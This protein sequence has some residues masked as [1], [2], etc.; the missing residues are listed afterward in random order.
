MKAFVFY[1]VQRVIIRGWSCS[2]I[3][4]HRFGH[5]YDFEALVWG[6]EHSGLR[7]PTFASSLFIII[8]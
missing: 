2:C 3:C 6:F 7:L 8:V 5:S 4:I 1:G